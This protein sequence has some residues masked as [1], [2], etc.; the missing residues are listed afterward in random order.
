MVG[1][2]NVI[3]HVTATAQTTV[4]AMNTIKSSSVG[5][6]YS[7][8]VRPFAVGTAGINNGI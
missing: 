7:L 5:G 1:A 2:T 3:V 8:S 4:A 6:L